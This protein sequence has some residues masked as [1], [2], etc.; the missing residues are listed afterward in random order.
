MKKKIDANFTENALMLF[1]NS[2]LKTNIY[3][4]MNMNPEAP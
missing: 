4:H 2:F 1:F 3:K